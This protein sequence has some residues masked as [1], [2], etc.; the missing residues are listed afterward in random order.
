MEQKNKKDGLQAQLENITLDLGTYRIL[1]HFQNR[2]DPLVIH[3]DKPARRFY[4]SLIALVV[5]EMKNRDKPEFIHT[6]K[7]EKTM[8]LLDDSL[9]GKNASKTLK[10]M[11]DKIR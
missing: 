9:A 11:W 8:K 2:T 7:H 5:N 1:L 10:G 4:F 3:F 6:R